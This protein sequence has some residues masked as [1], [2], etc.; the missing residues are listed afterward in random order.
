MATARVSQAAAPS[1]APANLVEQHAAAVAAAQ[2]AL[3]KMDRRDELAQGGTYQVRLNITAQ[4]DDG[5]PM[6]LDFS[7]PLT[8]GHD[9][10]AAL[11][12][13]PGG[14]KLFIAAALAK[15]NPAT[16]ETVLREVLADYASG[17]LPD[18]PAEIVEAVDAVL[19]Q[20]R[21][22]RTQPRRGSVKYIATPAQPALSVVASEPAPAKPKAPRAT[23]A[24]ATPTAPAAGKI[25][26]VNVRRGAA[27]TAAADLPPDDNF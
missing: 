6:R 27:P 24:A 2:Y 17:G 14:D 19:K 10:D 18:P 13:T 9:S 20:A 16:R 7:G 4:V 26:R 5:P 12:H 21:A 15:M 22:G 11:S 1:K 25:S 8:V 3:G 23:K